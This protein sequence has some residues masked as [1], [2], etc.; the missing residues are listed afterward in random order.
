MICVIFE[1]LPYDGAAEVLGAPA[2]T[3]KSRVSRGGEAL[4]QGMSPDRA[5]TAEPLRKLA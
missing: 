2:G 1:G 3:I 4:C 5:P